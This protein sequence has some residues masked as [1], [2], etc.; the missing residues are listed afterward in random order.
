VDYYTVGPG[1]LILPPA[2]FFT[3]LKTFPKPIYPVFGDFLTNTEWKL[4]EIRGFWA[5]LEHPHFQTKKGVEKSRRKIQKEEK[6]FTSGPAR[7]Q[8]LPRSQGNPMAGE[9]F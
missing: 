5:V 6:Y 4:A 7:T 9:G 3:P 8:T 2:F 1:A